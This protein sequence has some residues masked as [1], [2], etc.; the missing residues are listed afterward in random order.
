MNDTGGYYIGTDGRPHDAW[1]RPLE[2]RRPPEEPE[3]QAEAPTATDN[4]SDPAPWRGLNV[5]MVRL[6]ISAGYPNPAAVQAATDDDLLAID[7][8]GPK[9]VA[10]I[11]KELGR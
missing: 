4:S 3:P 10:K 2:P 5:A 11:R 6:L 9:A 8:V 1:G 7:G